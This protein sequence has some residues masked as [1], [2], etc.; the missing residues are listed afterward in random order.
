MPT[1]E[2][3]HTR[4]F[5]HGRTETIRSS[6]IESVAFVKT[7]MSKD[8]SD[9]AKFDALKKAIDSH[10]AYARDATMG[11]GVDRHMMGLLILSGAS[12]CVVLMG[13][14]RVFR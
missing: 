2:T 9:G 12:V 4:L 8:A 10:M 11:L 5:Y 14:S 1:Y 7:M 3:G 13:H 6:S